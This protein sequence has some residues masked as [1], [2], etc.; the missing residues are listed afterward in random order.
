MEEQHPKDNPR[1]SSINLRKDP[2][3]ILKFG[4]PHRMIVK[5]TISLKIHYFFVLRY[6]HA[7]SHDKIKLLIDIRS[8]KGQTFEINDDSLL[9]FMFIVIPCFLYDEILL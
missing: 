8:P 7:S 6:N 1:K 9:Q 5:I 4:Y 3:S 2:T